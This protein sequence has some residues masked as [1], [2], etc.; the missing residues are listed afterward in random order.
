[1]SHIKICNV[2]PEK[3]RLPANHTCILTSTLVLRLF[4]QMAQK[5]NDAAGCAAIID[6]SEYY[7]KIFDFASSYTAELISILL[8]KKNVLYR[9]SNI[10]FTI[11]TL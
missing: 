6:Q 4:T 8:V 11:F 9:H 1:M 5:L 7:A 10:N 3:S 2:N